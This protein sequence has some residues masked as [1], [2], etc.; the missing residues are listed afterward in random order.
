MGKSPSVGRSAGT[1]AACAAVASTTGGRAAARFFGLGAL[2]FTAFAAEFFDFTTL[3]DLAPLFAT[4]A[5]RANDRAFFFA[6]VLR[7]GFAFLPLF[8]F[9]EA[10]DLTAFFAIAL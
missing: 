3:F 6:A 2:R 5:L 8:A 7:A 4:R 1:G 9:R 10:A